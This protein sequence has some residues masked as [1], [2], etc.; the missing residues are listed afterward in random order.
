MLRKQAQEYKDQ[1]D[2]QQQVEKQQRQQKQAPELLVGLHVEDDEEEA[3][4]IWAKR[5]TAMLASMQLAFPA[6][7]CA[8]PHPSLFS[9]MD[10]TL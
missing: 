6:M 5:E 7:S 2:K 1:Q 9:L 10:A 3:L 8:H 4:R